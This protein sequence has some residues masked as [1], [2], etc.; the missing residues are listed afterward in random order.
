M[1]IEK[2]ED[3]ETPK[4]MALDVI[5]EK[6]L[7]YYWLVDINGK[8]VFSFSSAAGGDWPSCFIVSLV[9]LPSE[10][11]IAHPDDVQEHI[12]GVSDLS[13]STTHQTRNTRRRWTTISKRNNPQIYEALPLGKPYRAIDI[14]AIVPIF[15]TETRL[16][17]LVIK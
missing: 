10:T 2:H 7:P 13:Y 6:G 17:G 12:R 16:L 15:R 9:P 3:T 14:G 11:L 8:E 1:L 5:F 4:W